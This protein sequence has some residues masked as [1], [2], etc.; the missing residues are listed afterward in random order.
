MI[1]SKIAWQVSNYEKQKFN[2][3]SQSPLS[4]ILND[5]TSKPFRIDVTYRCSTATNATAPSAKHSTTTQQQPGSIQLRADAVT[6]SV[7]EATKSHWSEQKMKLSLGCTFSWFFQEFF[8]NVSQELNL[9]TSES[10]AHS[11]IFNFCFAKNSK[12]SGITF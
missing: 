7:S 5:N 10:L 1:K 3:I 6:D 8:F 2:K 12:N 4:I 11:R 9:K